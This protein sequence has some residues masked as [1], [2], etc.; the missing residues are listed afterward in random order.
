MQTDPNWGNFLYDS[1]TGVTTLL[2]FGAARHFDDEFVDGYFNIVWAAANNDP[3]FLMEESIR[4]KFLTG[5]ENSEMLHAHE[6]AGLILG[7]VS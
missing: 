7:E 3:K 4:M 2:D 6:M 1:N 5:E